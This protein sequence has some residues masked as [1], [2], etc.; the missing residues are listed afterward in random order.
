[1]SCLVKL[2][3]SNSAYKNDLLYNIWHGHVLM[4]LPLWACGSMHF[5]NYEHHL[6]SI[7]APTCQ[8]SSSVTNISAEGGRLVKGWVPVNWA[9]KI[10]DVSGLF[11]RQ[12]GSRAEATT[13]TQEGCHDV[14]RWEI[15]HYCMLS[16]QENIF[17]FSH[18]H[19]KWPG[20]Y[21]N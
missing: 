18:Y 1:M 12:N 10:S 7:R 14:R 5:Q 11:K 2:C 17:N 8:C 20:S 15:I 21:G 9:V 13:K 3:H 6:G 16:L 4:T 19:L